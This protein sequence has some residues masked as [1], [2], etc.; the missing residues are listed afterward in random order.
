[1]ITIDGLTPKRRRE[2]VK[3]RSEGLCELCHSPRGVENHHIIYGSGKRTQCETIYSLIGLC[4]DHH[5]GNEGIH[6]KDG[7]KLNMELKQNLERTYRKM[8]LAEEEIRYWLGG[9]YYL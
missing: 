9:R 1:M 2:I 5:Y 6:G 8:G 3:E 4:W 7:Y